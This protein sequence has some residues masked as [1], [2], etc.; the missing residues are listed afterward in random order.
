[1][2]KSDTQNVWISFSSIHN[3]DG[4]D[5]S[6]RLDF[7]TDGSYIFADNV[8]RLS[9]QE[10]DVTGLEGTCTSVTVTPGEIVVDR[11]GLVKSQMVFSEGRKNS[12]LYSTP[13]GEAT[14]GVD[15]R[16]IRGKLDER[17]GEIEIDYVVDMEHAVVARNRFHITVRQMEEKMGDNIHG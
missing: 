13:F 12:F 4:G 3:V 8:G 11:D 6:D 7:T 2:K 1:M 5:D 15:T 14:M 10:S 9:Y 17:G 16:R